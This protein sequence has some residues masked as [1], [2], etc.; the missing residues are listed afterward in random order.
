MGSTEKLSWLNN[1]EVMD[2]EYSSHF[3]ARNEGNSAALEI[4]LVLLDGC[5]KLLEGI[6]ETALGIGE[7]LE[8]KPILSRNEGDYYVVCQYKQMTSIDNIEIWHQTW[9]PFTLKMATKE[10][11]VYV[12]PF[13]LDY[14]FGILKKAKIN[15]FINKPT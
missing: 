1:A 10:G 4:E 3:V 9:L 13:E 6:R 5:K 7:S 2:N 12:V 14:K 8:F 11:E 15:T